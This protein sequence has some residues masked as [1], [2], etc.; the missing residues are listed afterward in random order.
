M[1]KLILG[2]S[3]YGKTEY[4]F[5]R[6]RELVNQGNDNILLIT[7]EQFS[8]E[9]EKRL[10]KDLGTK[11]INSVNYSTFTRLANQVQDELGGEGIPV[12]SPGSKA[13]LMLQAIEECKDGLELFNKRL[14]SVNFVSSMIKIYDEM[15]SCDLTAEQVFEQTRD[16]ENITLKCKMGDISKIMSA[17]ENIIEKR[18]LDPSDELTRLYKKISGKNYFKDKYIFIDGFNGFVAQEYKILELII[19]EAG[20]VDITLCSDSSEIRDNDFSIFTYVNKSISIIERIA[21]KAGISCETVYLSENKRAANEELLFAE[22]HIFENGNFKPYSN[23]ENISI[24]VAKNISDECEEVSR[25][26]RGLLRS[27]YKASEITVITRDLDKYRDELLWNFKKYEIPYFNDERQPIKNQPLVVFCEYLLRCV[28]LSLRSD[29]IISLAKTGLTSATESEINELEN[30]VYMWNINGSAWK[31]DFEKSTKGF[32]D[33]IDD[34][35]KKKLEAINC[36]RKKLIA[37]ILSFKK[38]VK[39]KNVLDIS[40]ELYNT[41]IYFEADRRI[42]ENAVFLNSIGHTYLAMLQGNVWDCVMNILDILPKLLPDDAISVKDYARLF[43]LI[44]SLED[45]GVIPTGIDN[46]QLGQADRIRTDNPRAVFVLGANEEEFPKSASSSGLLSLSDRKIL[47]ENDFKLY[48]YS[49]IFIQQEK[50][51]AYMACTCAREKVFISYLSGRGGASSPSEIVSSFE[52]MFSPI[53]VYTKRD[54][55][56][57]DLIETRENAFELM[58][59]EYLVNSEFSSSLKKYFEDD[60]RTE[61]IAALAENTQPVIS[62]KSLSERLFKK[63]IT[64]SASRLEE[65]YNCAF[66]YF[67]KFGLGARPPQKA[68]IDALQRGTLI[69]YVFEKLLSDY[70]KEEI[71][72]KNDA[73]LCAL[74]DAYIKKYFEEEMGQP[75]ISGRFNYNY[76]RISKLIY[77]VVIHLAEE[78]RISDFVPTDFEL[79]IDMDSDVKPEIIELENGG[80]IAIRGSVDRVDT[81]TKDGKDYIRVV[82]YKS[83]NKEFELSDVMYGLNLQMFLYLFSLINEKN[84]KYNKTPAGVL[85]VH[86]SQKTVSFGSKDEALNGID[87]KINDNFKMMGV[88]ISD[89]DDDTVANAMEHEVKGEFIP[90]KKDKNGILKGSIASLAEL[91][92]IHKKVNSL[93]AEM[94]NTLHDGRIYRNPVKNKNHKNTCE[95]CDF[96]DVCANQRFIE[97]RVVPDLK[98]DEIKKILVKEYGDNE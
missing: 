22:K 42:R 96:K 91:G 29:D 61:S 56:D 37:P 65:Y 52:N 97:E 63:D 78:F 32:T 94:G 2:R 82:D 62:D 51:F 10:L 9:A 41:I 93:V 25:R 67:C 33:S 72:A 40:K 70:S 69:H 73:E 44:V 4:V 46:V 75:E 43:S 86:A 49:D 58:S 5:S 13:V 16:I 76:R 60:S 57:I 14:D 36:T 31:N 1:L 7:P 85:Y 55:N 71:C 30:Y 66:R 39:N 95:Y 24:Y 64:I 53:S 17:Y 3:G 23:P 20:E 59:A 81:F 83:G 45:M 28:H 77:S 47:I 11:G 68:E 54:I 50:Y 74:V 8:L 90:V 21:F 27:G 12:L 89:E 35:D 84:E 6:I 80:K 34:E 87:K 19:A 88:V 79:K 48:S 92:R 98:L 38:A 15:K 18:F 26:I